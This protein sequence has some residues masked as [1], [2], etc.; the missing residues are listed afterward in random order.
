M[1]RTQIRPGSFLLFNA[2]FQWE[3]RTGLGLGLHLQGSKYSEIMTLTARRLRAPPLARRA[4]SC[5][6]PI[7]SAQLRVT[8]L[9]EGLS[10][11]SDRDS[12]L[13]KAKLPCGQ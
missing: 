5:R 11:G 8:Y 7:R 2:C 13:T 10:L 4:H 6:C 1:G 3:C 9:D 12:G